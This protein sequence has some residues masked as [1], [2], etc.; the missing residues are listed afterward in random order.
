MEYEIPYLP[1]QNVEKIS[2]ANGRRLAEGFAKEIAARYS[3]PSI[4]HTRGCAVCQDRVFV[5]LLIVLVVLVVLVATVARLPA[6]ALGPQRGLETDRD[7]L[8]GEPLALR[9]LVL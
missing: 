7:P 1:I 6:A 9:D 3:P 5:R 8:Q 4:W 2:D